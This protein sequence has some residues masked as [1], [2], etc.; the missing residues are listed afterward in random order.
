[1]S[2][3]APN[4]SF[5]ST[6]DSCYFCLVSGNQSKSI[7]TCENLLPS[8]TSFRFSKIIDLSELDFFISSSDFHCNE[9]QAYGAF[10][11]NELDIWIP[12]TIA[13]RFAEAFNPRQLI[14]T[15]S[16]CRIFRSVNELI[17]LAGQ[18]SSTTTRFLISGN[19]T[20]GIT[21]QSHGKY[22]EWKRQSSKASVIFENGMAHLQYEQC[23]VTGK[24]CILDT[25]SILS[26]TSKVCEYK[27][28][29][30]T[31]ICCPKTN[32]LAKQEFFDGTWSSPGG[33]CN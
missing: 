17:G 14:Y 18:L 22:H 33:S 31:Q 5:S 9:I 2:F 27:G 16:S 6:L 21:I 28:T 25:N 20:D 26:D 13:K 32:K 3:I 15:G 19:Q 11:G 7:K 23:S 29:Q 8:P 10:D 1:M 24:G 4:F 30:I 12:F